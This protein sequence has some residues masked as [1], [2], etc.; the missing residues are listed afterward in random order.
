MNHPSLLSRWDSL[1]KMRRCCFPFEKSSKRKKSREK[2]MRTKKKSRA[3]EKNKWHCKFN[4]IFIGKYLYNEHF[5]SYIY[6]FFHAF[7]RWCWIALL[8]LAFLQSQT[9]TNNRKVSRDIVFHLRIVSTLV[10]CFILAWHF[11]SHAHQAIIVFGFYLSLLLLRKL[12]KRTE[13]RNELLLRW[14]I[15]KGD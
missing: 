6:F 11:F 7:L 5:L 2:S 15:T 1:S 12:L 8:V 10:S 4:R 13:H 3:K 9:W 14:K